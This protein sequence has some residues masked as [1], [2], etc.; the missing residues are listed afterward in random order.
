MALVLVALLLY[1]GFQLLL[2]TSW[3]PSFTLFADGH[4]AEHFQAMDRVF[5]SVPVQAGTDVRALVIDERSLPARYLY[6]GEERETEAFLARTETTGLVVLRGDT[7]VHEQYRSGWSEASRATSWSVAKSVVS[8]LVGI[9]LGEGRI[10]SLDDPVTRYV[11][12]LVGSGYDGV[13]LRHLLTMSSGVDFDE[14]YDSTFSDINWIFVRSMALGRPMLDYYSGLERGRDPGVYNEYAS[15][16]TGVLALVLA[17]ATGV[18]PAEYLETR[19]WQPAGMESDAFWNTDR[20]G[21]EI[22]FCC[23]NAVLR[24]WARFGL[25][26]LENG[27]RDGSRILPE[28]WVARSVEPEA[29]HLQPGPNPDSHWTFGYGYKWWIPEDREDGEFTAIG[30]YGQYIYVNP[31]RGVIVV[32]SGTD[33]LFDDHDHESVALFRAIARWASGA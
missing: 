7:L 21:A 5:P 6:L 1:G 25:L 32:K 8:A 16:D 23:L 4:R 30:I 14:G 11:P 12:E 9:A 22:G 26:Y 33:P 27:M 13:P 15:S 29:P 2:T 19:L 20:S 24:D 10:E 3:G 31:A 18:S 28:D 17:R